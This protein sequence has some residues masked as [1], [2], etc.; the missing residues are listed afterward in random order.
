MTKK[1]KKLVIITGLSGSGKTYTL[2]TL[3]DI[4][5]YCIDNLPVELIPT[6]LNLIN[7][8]KAGIRKI[9]I[10]CD[11]REKRFLKNFEATYSEL[12]SEKIDLKLLFME[13]NDP[14]LLRRYSETRRP[15]PLRDESALS[16][17]IEKERKMLG[18]IRSMADMIIDTSEFNVHQLKSYIVKKFANE[19]GEEEN[20]AINIISFG[21]KHG[22]PQDMDMLLDVRF[23]PNPYFQDN[24]KDLSGLDR[25]VYDF[26]KNNPQYKEFFLKLKKLLLFLIP[27]YQDEGKV[28]FNIAFGCTGGRHRSVAVSQEVYKLLVAKGYTVFINHR[29]VNLHG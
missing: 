26:V 9:A 20:F 29:D 22:L 4:G 7:R 23:L 16:A 5:Y 10:I 24:L 3:E 17:M 15:H 27:Q 13:A 12:S 19:E 2:H 1:N 28:Y 6:F 21:Y 11:I 25:A 14:V 8:T 18:V